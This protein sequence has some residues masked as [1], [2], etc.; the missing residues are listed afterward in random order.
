MVQRGR[1]VLGLALV[2]V[3]AVFVFPGASSALIMPYSVSLTSTG[4]SPAVTRMPAGWPLEFENTD[5]VTHSVVFANGMCSI[6]VAPGG[7]GQCSDS[8]YPYVG[9]YDYTV[10][11]TSPA[12]IVVK[13]IRRTVSLRNRSTT[14]RLGSQV[15]LHGRLWDAQFPFPCSAGAPQPISV[16]ARPYVGHPFHRVAVVSATVPKKGCG[17]LVWRVPVHPRSTMTYRAIAS[18]QPAGG[19]VWQQA[20]SKLLLVNVRR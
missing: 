18:Y 4:P 13:A 12:Q 11:G 5:T 6:D 16:I 8:F 3:L 19:K 20:R 17:R 7:S 1:L 9:R 15:T 14:I 2:G 10:D